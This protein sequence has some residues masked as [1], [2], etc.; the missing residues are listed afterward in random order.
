VVEVVGAAIDPAEL[1]ELRDRVETLLGGG[2]R[3]LLVDL[4][5]APPCDDAVRCALVDSAGWLKAHQGWLRVFR[6]CPARSDQ[7]RHP[8]VGVKEATLLELFAIYRAVNPSA[9]GPGGH[10][11]P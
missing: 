5:E 11:G 6:R 2:V 10:D 8:G 1:G 4:S 9:T 3:N 7:H